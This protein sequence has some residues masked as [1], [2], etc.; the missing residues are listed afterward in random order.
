LRGVQYDYIFLRR[1]D[2]TS[3]FL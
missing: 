2:I 1:V 3:Y